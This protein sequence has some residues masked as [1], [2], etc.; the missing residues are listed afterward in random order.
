[1][2]ETTKKKIEIAPWLAARGIRI[3]DYGP[4][5]KGLAARAMRKGSCFDGPAR[6]F[7]CLWLHTFP[8][9]S[10]LAVKK[11]DGI[12]VPLRAAEIFEQTGIDRRH[13]RSYMSCLEAQGFGKAEGWTKGQ[14]RLYL[15]LQPRPAAESGI[16]T[17]AVTI[18]E[19]YPPDLVRLLT[20][21]RI[22][23]PN[24]VVTSA[25]TIETL[26]E[27]ARGA[28]EAE[29]RL[30]AVAKQVCARPRINKEETVYTNASNGTETPSPPVRPP[31]A[32]GDSAP[33]GAA[34]APPPSTA[35]IPVQTPAQTAPVFH[36]FRRWWAVW[37]A[38]KGT[39]HFRQAQKAWNQYVTPA[40][41]DACFECTASYLASLDDP[42]RGYN[43][44]NFLREQAED[45]FMARW[46]EAPQ[47]KAK[48]PSVERL[49]D[50]L[51]P[52]VAGGRS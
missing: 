40:N 48:G 33:D 8:Y 29:K 13:L 38:T 36:S 35:L 4:L 14:I 19:G 9:K 23:I 25:V 6:L 42:R 34:C 16:V 10:E 49:A 24:T 46:P 18:F 15:W 26:A 52:V 45:G 37:S 3:G 17:R 21:Y 51:R 50:L 5:T 20:H 32:N 31:S 2:S 41:I 39:N 27:A 7:F 12:S 30:R 44:E 22:R 47:P 43:P 11:R 1:M 28:Y